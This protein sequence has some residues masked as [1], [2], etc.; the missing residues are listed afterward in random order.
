MPVIVS[1]IKANDRA[2]EVE[3]LIAEA[4]PEIQRLPGCRKYALHRVR[5]RSHPGEFVLIEDWETDED[6]TGYGRAPVLIKLHEDLE[7]LIH[8][9][10]DYLV[11][12]PR[13]YGEPGVGRL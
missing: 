8:S 9:L 12:D 3:R 5:G 1:T 2:E 10:T 7:P 6:L 13:P 4:M 11:V